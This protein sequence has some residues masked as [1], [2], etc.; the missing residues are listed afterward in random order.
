MKPTKRIAF[1]S[2][3][4]RAANG[5]TVRQNIRLAEE[6][7]VS[8]WKLGWAV[9]CPHLNTAFFDGEAEDDVWLA[10]DLAFIDRLDPATDA[11]VMLPGW[12]KSE[13]SCEELRLA[14]AR[15]ITIVYPPDSW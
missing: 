8:Y 1:I 9:I 14:K 7:A 15:D 11:L 10:G 3:P 2:G 4:Y 12:E 5:R 13:G 6:F